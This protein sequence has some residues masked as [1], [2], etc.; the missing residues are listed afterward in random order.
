M[1]SPRIVLGLDIGTNSVGSM[2]LDRE[3]GT[4]RTA[5]SVFPAGVDESEDKRGEPKNAKRRMTRRTRITLARRASR[6]RELKRAL[7][8]A[9]LLPATEHEFNSL[10]Q[11]TDPWALRRTGLDAALTPHEFGRVLLHLAQRRGALGLKLAPDDAEDGAGATADE[12]GKVKRAIG[13]V[14]QRMLTAKARTFGEFMWMQREQRVHALVPAADGRAS[15]RN[16][17]RR[18]Y[19]DAIRNKAGRYEHCADRAMVRHEFA[20]LWEAQKRAGGPTAALLTDALR[21]RLDDESGDSVWRHRGLLFGQR[22]QS[23]D[24]GSLGRCVLEPTE[25]CAP[26][27]DRHASRYLVV[28]TVNNLRVIERGKPKRPLSPEERSKVLAYLSGPLGVQ[29]RGKFKGTPKRTVTITDL[30]ECMGWGRAT[31]ASEFRFSIEADEDRLINTDWFHREIVHGAV[32]VERWSAMPESLREGINRAVLSHDPDEDGHAEALKSGVMKWGGLAE[33]QTDALVAA[34]KSRP[35][36]DAKRLNVSRRAARNLLAVMDCPEPWPDR[37]SPS[38]YRW[39]TQIEGRKLIAE[40]ADFKD[41]TTGHPLDEHARRRYA[42]GAK[43]LSARDRHYLRKHAGDLPPAPMLTNPVVRKAIHEVRRHIVEYLRVFGRKPDEIY[44]ELAREAKMGATQSDRLL[45][46]N[47]LRNRI[48][49]DIDEHFNLDTGTSTQR[50]AA[51][52][53]VIL[54]VQQGETCP[55]CG[56][57]GLTPR[58]AALGE[59]C[60]VSHILPRGSG[61]DNNLSNIVLGHTRC[62]REMGRRTPRQYWGQTLAGGFEE[63]M[64]FIEGIFGHVARPKPAEVRSAEGPALWSCY[65]DFRDDR[66]K[67]EQFAKNIDD[68]QHMTARQDAATKFATR[69]VMAYLSDALFR[70]QGL[71]ERGGERRIFATDGLWT[72]RLRREWGLFFDPHDARTKGLADAEEH[73]RKEKNR[74]DHRHHAVDAVLIGLCSRSVQIRWEE[75]EKAAEAAGVN[76]ANE[77]LMDAYR[78]AHPLPPPAPFRDRDDLRAAVRRAVFGEERGGNDVPSKP[79]CHRPVKRK[80][81][82]ALHKA[83]QYGPVFGQSALGERT[84]VLNR[85]VVRQR[86]LGEQPTD[87]LSPSQ[88][89]MPRPESDAEA[90]SRVAEQLKA[91][92]PQLKPR[93]A[94]AEAIKLVATPGFKFQSVD[95]GPQKSGIVR[96]LG[97][98]R[99]L[100]ILLE[101][102][103]LDPDKFSRSDL[104]RTLQERGPLRHRSGVPIHSVRL[105]WANNEPVPIRRVEYDYGSAKPGKSCDDRTIRLYDSQNNH[106]I[107][108]RAARNKK[109]QE[110]FSGEIVSAYEAAQR[111]LAK[112]RALRAARI[113]PPRS[114]RELDRAERKRLTPILRQ[115]EEAHPLVDRS[116]NPEKGGAFVMSL[117]EGEMVR[118]RHKQ[119]REVGYFVVAKLDKP[120]SIVLVPHWDARAAGVRKDSAGNPV[121]DSK[122]DEFTATPSDLITLAPPGHPHAV[123]VHVS[124]LGTVT[125]LERD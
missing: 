103:G 65:F 36:L 52:D 62:N 64:R 82:G 21:L 89:R 35:R 42:T 23:W 40:D 96:D 109:G 33:R 83:T 111:K 7:V 49:R 106:H 125:V 3:E 41:I 16:G 18:E 104:K 10:L 53:R 90:V 43:G 63:G 59:D 13:E 15:G 4:L 78:R 70:G 122:R 99:L 34:W 47:R 51:E 56:Q 121:P 57:K 76:T 61:G 66:R 72:S 54:A 58:K 1:A 45:F 12:D 6:K 67:V 115:I 113:P 37:S 9:G 25:R 46:R 28:E 32:T 71:P 55:L 73:A 68:I 27:A 29:T 22:R 95:A 102:R 69:Q 79:V 86:V 38:G 92:R 44:I 88:L 93:D 80:L 112:L 81:V 107:E 124:P 98:R 114:F 19:R 50:R 100:R 2:W 74:G 123:K 11:M 17:G 119:T 48:R 39:L 77:E 117:A 118:M 101:E 26:H 110:V 94:K 91:Q 5:T 108:I 116:H 87:F 105:L 60:E 84:R 20:V 30:R 31:K 24:L 97:L 85:V 8:E 75:R 120:Q 14:R